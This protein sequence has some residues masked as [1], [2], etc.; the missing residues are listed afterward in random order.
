ML[1]S[2]RTWPLYSQLHVNSGLPAQNQASQNLSVDDE[3]CNET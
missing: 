3:G 1:P 2:D